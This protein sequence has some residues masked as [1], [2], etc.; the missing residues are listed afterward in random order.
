MRL[1]TFWGVKDLQAYAT[2]GAKG[3]QMVREVTRAFDAIF[4]YDGDEAGAR[5][6][7]KMRELGVEHA[8][9]VPVSPDDMDDEQLE[10]LTERIE[11]L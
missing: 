3:N 8:Y 7:K 9:C 6:C 1:A 4:L 11:R 5:A 2:L 10:I